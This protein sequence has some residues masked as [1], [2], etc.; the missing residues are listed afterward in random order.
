M[1]TVTY[2]ANKIMIINKIKYNFE[3]IVF[4]LKKKLCA[5]LMLYMFFG[6]IVSAEAQVNGTVLICMSF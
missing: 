6:L 3:S 4:V 2:L 1:K 5:S